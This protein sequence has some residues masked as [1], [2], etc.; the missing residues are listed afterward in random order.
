M[1]LW[2]SKNVLEMKV[3]CD[4]GRFLLLLCG[5]NCACSDFWKGKCS[6]ACCSIL[7]EQRHCLYC[8]FSIKTLDHLI[9]YFFKFSSINEPATVWITG[10]GHLRHCNTQGNCCTCHFSGSHEHPTDQGRHWTCLQITWTLGL[11][12]AS[13]FLSMLCAEACGDEG[14]QSWLWTVR[15][16]VRILADGL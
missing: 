8:R 5:V 1:W 14:E 12:F 3:S 7:E 15:L 9:S 16:K 10:P 6:T 2:Q 4:T 11:I 13:F